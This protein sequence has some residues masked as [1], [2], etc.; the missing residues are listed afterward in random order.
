[1]DVRLPD[2]TMVQNVPD[3]ITKAELASKLQANG[4]DVSKLMPKAEATAGERATA[5]GAG[6]QKGMV[7]GLLG[8]PVDTVENIINLGT[9]AY[10]AGTGKGGEAPQPLQ[11]SVGGSAWIADKLRG[12]GFNVDNPRPDDPASR[13]LHT[14]G[15]IAGVSALPGAGVKSTLTAAAGGSIAGEVLGPEWEGVGAMTPQAAART[16]SAAKAAVANPQTVQRN[17][18]TF[19]TAGTTPDVAQATDSNFFRGLT[20]VVGRVPGGQG[21]IA[22]FREQEQE[23]LGKSAKTGVSAESAGRAIKEGITGDGG[24]LDRTKQTWVKLDNEVAA[25]VPGNVGIAPTN[26]MAALDDLTKTTKGAEQ[27]SKVFQNGKVLDIKRAAVSD[28]GGK[29][30]TQISILGEDGKP[31][32]TF[33]VGGVAPSGQLPYQAIRELRSR[34]GSMLDDSLVSGIPNGELKKLYG[35][36]SKDL[37]AAANGAGAGKEFARQS[38]YYKARMERIENTLDKVLGQG[39]APEDIFKS[40]SPTDVE[41][42]NKVRRVMRS[43][44]PEER[45]VLSDAVVNRLGRAS[46]GKQDATGEKFSSETFLTNWSRINDSAKAQLFPDTRTKLDAIAKVS[47]DIRAGKTPFGNPSGTGQAATAAGVYG[48]VPIAAGMATTG[49]ATGNT[50]LVGAAG[51]T[52]AISGSLIAGANIGSK[53]LTSPKVVDW[54][55]KSGKITTDEQKVAQLGRLAVIY[56]E[57]KDEKLKAELAQYSQSLK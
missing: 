46:P 36:L 10:G 3:N 48:S 4:Y 57:T 33:E 38:N 26:T 51:A 47:E 34:V 18:E 1:M 52:L 19:K 8:L 31:L 23:A 5:L 41:S 53:M 39:K 13:M 44:E 24:F 27:L 9:A 49:I 17:Q 20:N 21:V 35:G 30:G 43:L 6:A 25:K 45:Q 50:A 7:A 32:S 37:E 16:A 28:L 22:K 56:N 40:I 11:G 14:G 15:T 12:A 42:V 55:A 54:L 2:G 29:P